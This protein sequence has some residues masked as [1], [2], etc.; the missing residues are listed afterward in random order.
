MTTTTY[1]GSCH[2]RLVTFG[3]DLDDATPELLMQSQVRYGNGRENDWM[4]TPS[5][6]GHL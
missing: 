1:R 2:C 4:N 3:A 6:T 5:V